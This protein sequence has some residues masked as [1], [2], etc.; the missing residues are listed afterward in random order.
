MIGGQKGSRKKI[1][2]IGTPESE[3]QKEIMGQE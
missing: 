3:K 2:G 1:A